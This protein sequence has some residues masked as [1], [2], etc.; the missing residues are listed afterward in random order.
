M[1]YAR[2]RP[3]GPAPWIVALL[4]LLFIPLA[5][6]GTVGTLWA[7]GKV[8]PKSWFVSH[9]PLPPGHI[10]VPASPAKIPAYTKI[11]REHLI[12]PATGTL[13]FVAVP[14]G[15]IPKE[16]FLNP[17]DVIGRVLKHDKPANYAFTERDF[18]PKGTRAG[19]AGAIPPGKRSLLIE[20]SK[21]SGVFGLKV[22]DHIDL[23]ATIP[24]EMPKGGMTGK[25]NGGFQAEAQMASMQKLANVRILAQDA[26]LLTPV[27]SRQKPTVSKSI[28]QGTTVRNIPVE[29]VTIALAP[30]EIAPV[31]QALATEV[32]VMC[33]VRSGQPDD[34]E[35]H[36][37]TPG[38]DPLADITAI[39]T[40]SGGKREVIVLPQHSYGLNRH[41]GHRHSRGGSSRHLD[42]AS[43][44]Q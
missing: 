35:A 9:D 21:V 24:V 13:A 17:N 43:N 27:T 23:V 6:A 34:P 31:T 20:V 41:D 11:T 19:L 18:Y 30:D 16:A 8:D 40:L 26:V 39:D 38:S 25:F 7:F 42:A 12:D 14:E 2:S 22:G 37:D 28:S 10:A 33:V 44:S 4:I 29:E 3:H 1:P 32:N 15:E 36:T 5:A